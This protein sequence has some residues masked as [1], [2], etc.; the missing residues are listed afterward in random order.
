M[1]KRRHVE[2]LPWILDSSIFQLL[3]LIKWQVSFYSVSAQEVSHGSIHDHAVYIYLPDWP[4][5]ILTRL[6][7]FQGSNTPLSQ[8]SYSWREKRKYFPPCACVMVWI[9]FLFKNVPPHIIRIPAKNQKNI[10][11][12][13]RGSLKTK[14]V[15]VL[16]LV[17]VLPKK[18]KEN[19]PKVMFNSL[20][21]E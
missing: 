9:L 14:L 17:T 5:K 13:E 2:K 15:I 21:N 6:D 11:T 7:A 18:K 20:E 4:C 12:I 1:G 16:V 3:F 10:K 8:P 19:I